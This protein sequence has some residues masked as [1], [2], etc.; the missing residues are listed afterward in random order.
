MGITLPRL[1]RIHG[2]INR[3]RF[4]R[5][6]RTR[7]RT[8]L[9]AV[10]GMTIC[11]VIYLVT[12]KTLGYFLA[13]DELGILL[14]MKLFQMSWILLFAMLVFS[15]MVSAVSTLYLSEDNEILLAAPVPP[16]EIFHMRLTSITISTAWMVV[17]FSLPV[18]V[19]CGILFHAPW[20][21]WLLMPASVLL[22]S[23][24]ATSTAVLLSICLVALFPA[25]RTKDIALYLSLCFGLFLYLIFRMIRP[26]D[27][28]NPEQFAQFI[29]YFDAISRPGGPWIPAGWAADMLIG[30]LRRNSVDWILVGLLATTPL[31]LIWLGEWA[32]DKL[33]VIGFSRSQESFGGSRAF[34]RFRLLPSFFNNDAWHGGILRN[35]FRKE[36]HQFTRDSAE[37]SQFFM[38]A[39][40]VVVYLY[41]FKALPLD[42]S[43]FPSIYVANLICFA[44]IGLTGF[45]AAALAARFAYPSIGAEKG[46]F[47][48]IA[49]SPLGMGRF[50]WY[51]YLFYALPF[52]ALTA[53][54]LIASNHL[55]QISGSL[56]WISLLTSELIALTEV[57]LAIGFGAIFADFKSENRAA[58]MGPGAI[59]FLFTGV[60]YELIVL[61]LGIRATWL[62][63][64]SEMRGLDLMT[65]GVP[66]VVIWLAGSTLVSL[67][68][69]LFLCRRG[70]KALRGW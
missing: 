45:I 68:A 25:R 7:L 61:G 31:L 54:L 21:Y 28:V 53:I 69:G 67:A 51:K 9:L 52:S 20:F 34:R 58:S 2:L 11:V 59:L 40:L 66:E 57:A 16:K 62:I 42:R 8:A 12:I 27:L 29:E 17:I 50:L 49:S 55:L 26:E 64:R 43:P 47:Y 6:R 24:T 41:N 5:G 1:L 37:W 13:Q 70:M 30:V 15:S 14:S 4:L 18:F 10:L 22:V 33:F 63:V 19:A 35:L 36:L 3:N 56:W 46:A 60:L 23:S 65:S 48:L 38:I 44:N 32:M 39:A